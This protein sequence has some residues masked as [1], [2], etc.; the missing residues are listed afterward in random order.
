MNIT[1]VTMT[2]A[3][4]KVDPAL[5]YELSELYDLIEWGILIYPKKT[6][7]PRYPS[8][9]FID[10]FMK[11]KPNFVK[12]AGHLCGSAVD[13]FFSGNYAENSRFSPFDRIQLNFRDDRSDR[14]NRIIK[15]ND[16]QNNFKRRVIVQL[17]ASNANFILNLKEKM[18]HYWPMILFD[19]SGGKGKLI[20]DISPPLEGYK[21]GYAGGISPETIDP[22]L[23]TLTRIVP[24]DTD[25]WLDME[26]GIRTG[27]EFDLGKVRSVM[28]SITD[29]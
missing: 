23:E 21:C 14:N 6:G 28:D 15:I 9:Q 18:E 27:N 24:D 10:H 8:N 13:Y 2:G 4:D 7:T 19:N 17:N 3:D 5:L 12:T 25:I 29:Y 11:W 16:F 20:T 26:S 1:K 22:L